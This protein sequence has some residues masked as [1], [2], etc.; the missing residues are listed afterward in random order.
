MA[1]TTSSPARPTSSTT[2]SSRTCPTP[3][4]S[5]CW[6]S[7]RPAMRWR[8]RC[9]TTAT[10]R[11]ST[12]SRAPTCRSS[13]A[14]LAPNAGSGRELLHQLHRRDHLGPQRRLSD[15]VR[16]RVPV[17]QGRL[18]P[19]RL[20]GAAVVCLHLR[21]REIQPVAER[22]ERALADQRRHLAVQRLHEGVPPGGSAYGKK[23]F[24]QPMCGATTYGGLLGGGVLSCR[25]YSRS[26]CKPNDV[27]NPYWLSPASR[28]SIRRRRICR[29]R[30]FRT[31]RLG[32]QRVQLPVRRDA[33]AELQAQPADGHAV[34][35]VRRGQPLRRSADD[36]G[37]RPGRRLRQTLAGNDR[38]RPALSLRRRRG[39]PFNANHQACAA[40]LSI[41]DPY[42]GQFDG[43]GAFREPAQLLGHLQ[44]GYQLSRV[45][46][47]RSRWRT[48]CRRASAGNTPRSRITGATHVLVHEPHRRAVFAARRQRLQP[49][50]ERADVPSLSLRAVFR[51]L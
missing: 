22:H 28:C 41:P 7:R 23:Q 4:R 50:R 12:T 37:H 6:G 42:T 27:A 9:R 3:W 10:F 11:S 45:S 5:S 39:G 20:R 44:V 47:R 30:S 21:D 35:S 49:R 32:R 51:N 24:G 17:R 8:P 38:R 48:C 25:R 16:L 13:L 43:I 2:R 1:A 40:A 14:V 46:P 15:L 18:Q 19:Q 36:A 34:L 31:G 29:S 33:A 26:T